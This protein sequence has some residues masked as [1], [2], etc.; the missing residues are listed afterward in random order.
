[1][2]Y[3]VLSL[4]NKQEWKESLQKLPIEQQDVYYT[5]E[6]YEL[7]EN[8]GDGKAQCFVFEKGEDVALYPFLLNSVNKLGFDFDDEYFDIQGAY[9]YNGV[10]SS[11]YET[12]FIDKFYDVFDEWCYNNNIVA[13]FTRFNPYIENH[14][15]SLNHRDVLLNR[16]TV[17]LDLTQSLDEIWKNSFTSKNRNIIRKAQ[18]N[19]YQIFIDNSQ[20]GVKDFHEIYLNTMKS[21]GVDDYYHFHKEMFD[22][23][24][25]SYWSDFLFVVDDKN[26]RLATMILM[27]YGEYAH[28]HLSGR[29]AELADNSV[30]NY[31]LFEA[32][33]TAKEKGAKFFHFGGGNNLDEHDSLFRFKKNFS[34][35]YLDFYIGKRVHNQNVYDKIVN[36]WQR[37]HPESYKENSIKLLGYRD[38]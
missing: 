26:N 3:K 32:I 15:F 25:S 5:P 16:K 22:L 38:N 24:V 30:N 6:Y 36:Q 28:Y 17:L 34:N 8:Y 13:E 37:K 12:G 9:G 35:D 20:V 31:V 10:I 11:N 2:S 27:I 18:K 19:G 23:M 21:I 1:M 29:N 4:D 7:Y 33:K 14:N